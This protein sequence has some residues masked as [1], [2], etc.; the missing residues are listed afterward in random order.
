MAWIGF[1]LVLGCC[2]SMVLPVPVQVT[3]PEHRAIKREPVA[4]DCGTHFA[5][6]FAGNA[7]LVP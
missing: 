3:G 2:C 7:I 5:Q 4:L 1:G 6:Y